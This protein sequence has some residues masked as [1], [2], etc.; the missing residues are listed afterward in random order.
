MRIVYKWASHKF[1]EEK[2]IAPYPDY[3]TQ[4]RQVNVMKSGTLLW[5]SE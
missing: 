1:D 4:K 3:R 5:L 2:E